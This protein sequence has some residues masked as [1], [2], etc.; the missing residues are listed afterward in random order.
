MKQEIIH[1]KTLKEYYRMIGLKGL[2]HPLMGVFSYE[3]FPEIQLTSAVKVTFAF[4]IISIKIDYDCKVQYGQTSYDFDEGVMGFI[5]PGQV[6]I[7][8][9]SFRIPKKGW[10][11]AIHPDLFAGL[12]L[13]KKIREYGFFDYSV[14]EALILSEE[15]EQSMNELFRTIQVEYDRTLDSFSQDV[16][17]S[18]ID[19]LLTFCNRYYNRQFLTRSKPNNELLAKFETLLHQY[20]YSDLV[21]EEGY[22]TV[23]Y[24]A[25]QLNVSP[26]YLSDV[27][28]NVSGQNAQQ[29]IHSKMIE[30][31][32]ELLS[33]TSLSVN[34]ISCQLGFEY[35]QSFSKLFKAK[36]NI[37]PLAFRQSF[38]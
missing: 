33:A 20:F 36:A 25:A 17:V 31:A 1:I 13:A 6:H 14:N 37:S 30:K 18:Q 9:S 8:D 24:F 11:L 34:E 10:S 32:K 7:I 21:E 3:G 29:H 4:Y 22:P 16:L 26:N 35:S 28:R 27:L 23:R 12:P 15:E 2:K 5:A 38:K 19:L